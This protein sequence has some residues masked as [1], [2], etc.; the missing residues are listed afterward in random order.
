[1]TTY[2]LWYLHRAGFKALIAITVLLIFIY[3][4]HRLRMIVKE[5]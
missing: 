2:M 1:M 3:A 5:D 4:I